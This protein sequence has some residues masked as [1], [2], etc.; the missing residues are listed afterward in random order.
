ME[1]IIAFTSGQFYSWNYLLSSARNVYKCPPCEMVLEVME[2]SEKTK[3]TSENKEFTAGFHA[4]LHIVITLIL[5]GMLVLNAALWSL[6]DRIGVVFM[7][8]AEVIFFLGLSFLNNTFHEIFVRITPGKLYLMDILIIAWS[9][10]AFLTF[11]ADAVTCLALN[12]PST[13]EIALD[14]LVSVTYFIFINSYL[15]GCLYQALKTIYQYYK[16][17]SLE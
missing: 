7:I 2:M 5:I 17:S 4:N 3:T 15:V 13:D 16:A 10:G 14:K 12:C 9:V 1:L 6:A 8:F 11:K